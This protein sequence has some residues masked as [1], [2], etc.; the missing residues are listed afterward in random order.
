MNVLR[1]VNEN[2]INL[3]VI[4]AAL[5]D[6]YIQHGGVNKLKEVYGFTPEAIIE[7]WTAIKLYMRF[8]VE[9]EQV[10]VMAS[11]DD[12]SL[13]NEDYYEGKTGCARC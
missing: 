7:N 9:R 8:A 1:A 13:G 12:K 2:R 6:E 3:K 5:P 10:A 4:N 11:S